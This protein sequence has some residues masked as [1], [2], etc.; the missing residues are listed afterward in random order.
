M[1]D[2]LFLSRVGYLERPAEVVDVDRLVR[3]VVENLEKTMVTEKMEI[4]Q[5]S[6]PNVYVPETLLTQ[7]FENLLG[8]AVRYAG[9]S[10]GQVEI[11]GESTDSRVRFY[12]RDHGQGIPL[13][14]RHKVFE[15]FYRGSTGKQKRGTGV[16]LATVQKIARLYGGRAWVEETPGG[17]ATFCVEM[18]DAKVVGRDS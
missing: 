13:A 12:V 1:E 14:E 17:G 8:N 4:L 10:G 16:G 3:D 9:K 2:L 6:L 5:E 15:L 7:L 11:W 18:E